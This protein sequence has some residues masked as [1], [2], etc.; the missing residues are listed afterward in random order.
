MDGRRAMSG[1]RSRQ[2]HVWLADSGI[3]LHSTAAPS[4]SIGVTLN[5][6]F[7]VSLLSICATLIINHF[8]YPL[9]LPKWRKREGV[10]H[11]EHQGQGQ[12]GGG[13]RSKEFLGLEFHATFVG[14]L[15]P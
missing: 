7:A 2:V 15:H 13:R 1:D 4:A 5:M 11:T 6:K 3:V 14:I 12:I 8:V 10:G 9:Y